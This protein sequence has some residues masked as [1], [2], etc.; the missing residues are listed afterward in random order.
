MSGYYFI[1]KSKK[2]GFTQKASF[3]IHLKLRLE[4]SLTFTRI[5]DFTVL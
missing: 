1:D 4:F 5:G 3:L 2:R